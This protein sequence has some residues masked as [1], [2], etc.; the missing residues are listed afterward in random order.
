MP[1]H[2]APPEADLSSHARYTAY[3]SYI[4]AKEVDRARATDYLSDHCPNMRLPPLL[5]LLRVMADL[6]CRMADEQFVSMG[7]LIRYLLSLAAHHL[8]MRLEDDNLPALDTPVGATLEL[9]HPLIEFEWMEQA[10][11]DR[12]VAK[13]QLS[14]A[15]AAAISLGSDDEGVSDDNLARRQA[16]S[17]SQKPSPEASF[18]PLPPATRK[19]PS[20]A[21]D[22]VQTRSRTTASSP[23]T[24]SRKPVG[25]LRTCAQ[26]ATDQPRFHRAREP[27][28]PRKRRA[29]AADTPPAKK[30]R[31]DAPT[32]PS[33]SAVNKRQLQ[34]ESPLVRLPSSPAGDS[35]AMEGVEETPAAQPAGRPPV[36]PL[37]EEF[38]QREE[39]PSASTEP[40][41]R[42][43]SPSVS[44]E[45]VS[46]GSLPAH[47]SEASADFAA[48]TIMASIAAT[49]PHP[50]PEH[51][52][53]IDEPPADFTTST[54]STALSL[55][56]IN[57]PPAESTASTTLSLQSSKT[58][59]LKRASE[60]AFVSPTQWTRSDLAGIEE[61]LT[62]DVEATNFQPAMGTIT[63][64]APLLVATMASLNM[65]GDL[66]PTSL[67][68]PPPEEASPEQLIANMLAYTEAD[69]VSSTIRRNTASVYAHHFIESRVQSQLRKLPA[70]DRAKDES[71]VRGS[72]KARFWVAIGLNRLEKKDANRI[73]GYTKRFLEGARYAALAEHCGPAALALRNDHWKISESLSVL[74]ERKWQDLLKRVKMSLALQ[75]LLIQYA[76]SMPHMSYPYAL[77]DTPAYATPINTVGQVGHISGEIMSP[78]MPRTPT[79]QPMDAREEPKTPK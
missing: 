78:Y 79:N 30:A 66:V 63:T 61:A 23:Q 6:Q 20:R 54:T 68:F 47:D 37:S 3:L 52:A 64:L 32:T 35:N 43:G 2:A 4:A 11:W 75:H 10:D 65:G 59:S 49:P 5:P 72:T 12:V 29:V 40:E 42:D 70:K 17:L 38:G 50:Q 58:P 25:G 60:A 14:P 15:A 36:N 44:A 77:M 45:P 33:F 51:S 1:T 22:G 62:A 24:H 53:L 57:E 56:K 74:P 13:L 67:A 39:S 76:G 71:R 55:A 69:S 34:L 27:T 8:T 16:V 9:L 7:L 73:R 21:P 28:P 31:A 46:S 18:G 26:T 48:A 19:L 41:Q